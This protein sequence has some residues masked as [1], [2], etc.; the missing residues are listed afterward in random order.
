MKKTTIYKATT[1]EGMSVSEIAHL[2]SELPGEIRPKV[3]T[4]LRGYVIK[5]EIPEI[6]DD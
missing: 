5:I 6:E 4:N 3:F 2:L 1:R